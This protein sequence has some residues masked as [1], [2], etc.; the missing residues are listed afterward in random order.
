MKKVEDL[1]KLAS[2]GT[3]KLMMGEKSLINFYHHVWLK[4]GGTRSVVVKAL[5]CKPEGRG[6]AS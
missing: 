5:C 3:L 4:F 6:F 1:V 2:D